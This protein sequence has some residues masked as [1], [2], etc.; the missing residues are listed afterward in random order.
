MTKC[1]VAIAEFFY[2]LSS[3][4]INIEDKTEVQKCT[5][6]DLIVFTHIFLETA[7]NFRKLAYRSKAPVGSLGRKHRPSGPRSWSSWVVRVLNANISN[8]CKCAFKTFLLY[9]GCSL[10]S[11]LDERLPDIRNRTKGHR[12]QVTRKRLA[13][14]WWPRI[15]WCFIRIASVDPKTNRIWTNPLVP[16]WSS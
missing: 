8:A 1:I 12:R 10:W 5:K 11:V 15:Q 3:F 6:F 2:E 9:M 4:Y 14:L 7:V 16:S 13:L